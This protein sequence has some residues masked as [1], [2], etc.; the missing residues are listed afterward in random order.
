[1]AQRGA[2]STPIQPD[3]AVT[4]LQKAGWQPGSDGVLTR[5]G[6]RF[7]LT[8][9]T[10]PDRPELPLMAMVIQQQLRKV[11]IEMK[12]NST[13]ASEIP[14]QHHAGNCNWRCSHATC[15]HARSN[16]HLIGIM[17]RRWRLGER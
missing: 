11:G 9:L 17:P 15:T 8:L 1:M 13:N 6:Q 3:S 16:R 2:A 14:A 10:F 7:S 4:L 12:I 5:N